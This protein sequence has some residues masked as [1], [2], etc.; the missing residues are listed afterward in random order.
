MNR[1]ERKS[2]SAELLA[3]QARYQIAPA[4]LWVL[5]ELRKH[6]IGL[7]LRHSSY[8]RGS[9]CKA[10]RT[11]MLSNRNSCL[12][13]LSDTNFHSNPRTNRI[14]VTRA[15]SIGILP[16]RFG[17]IRRIPL[18]TL[19]YSRAGQ[20]ENLPASCMLNASKT[21]ESVFGW[22]KHSVMNSGA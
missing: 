5:P 13:K 16:Q 14:A 11:T 22:S 12:R 19:T 10:R 17:T 7:G 3:T 1:V 20:S 2:A 15:D 9:E 4:T 8:G 6:L 18:M 21:V